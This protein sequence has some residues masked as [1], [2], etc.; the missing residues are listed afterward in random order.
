MREP[1]S[2]TPLLDSF[3][4]PL[5]PSMDFTGLL[6]EGIQA[7]QAMSSDQWTD[8]NEHDPGLT[9]LEQL[10]YA[11]TDLGLR[12]HYRVEDLLADANGRIDR[13]SLF[14]GNDIL[15]CAPLT[16]NDYR[17]YLYD[18]V[19]GLKNIWLEPVVGALPGLYRGLIEKFRWGNDDALMAD[20][21]RHLH[22]NRLLGDELVSVS[23]LRQQALPL[24]GIIQLKPGYQADQVMGDVLFNLDLKLAPCPIPRPIDARLA[25]GEPPDEIY[26]GP[27]LHY[28]SIDDADLQPRPTQVSL[29][30]IASIVLATAGV[31]RLSQLHFVPDPTQETLTLDP[32]SIPFID[33]PEAGADWPFQVIN[34]EGTPVTLN[35]ARV[36]HYFLKNRSD[37]L[38]REAAV[39]LSTASLAYGQLPSGRALEIGRYDSIQHQFPQT[40]GLGRYGVPADLNWQANDESALFAPEVVSAGVRRQAQVKQ[41]RAYLLLFEQVLSNAFAQLANAHQLFA[42]APASAQ[43]YFAQSLVGDASQPYAPPN[44][45]EVLAPPEPPAEPDHRWR[46]I[47]CVYLDGHTLCLRSARLASPQAAS[48]LAE[49]IAQAGRQPGNYRQQPDGQGRVQ[50]QLCDDDGVALAYAVQPSTSAADAQALIQRLLGQLSQAQAQ[51]A[52]RQHRQGTLGLRI[53]GARGEL[54]LC[55]YWPGRLAERPAKVDDVLFFG[56]YPHHYSYRRWPD[57]HWGLVLRHPDGHTLAVSPQR[58]ASETACCHAAHALADWVR[59]LACQCAPTGKHLQLLPEQDV[60]PPGPS[61]RQH[62]LAELNHLMARFD[63]YPERRNRFLNH[64]LARFNEHF[65]D[66]LLYSFDPRPA[67]TDGFLLELASWKAALL[68]N[69][70]LWSARRGHGHNFTLRL[71]QPLP[72][73][74]GLEQ[75]LAA[76][77]G[78]GGAQP[79][80][81]YPRSRAPLSATPPITLADSQ[82]DD[83]HTLQFSSQDPNLLGMLFKY[84][85]DE[86]RYQITHSDCGCFHHLLFSYP[87]GSQKPIL[88]GHHRAGLEHSRDRLIAW[89]RPQGPAWASLYAGEGLYVVEHLLLRPPAAELDA[90]SDADK[91]FY[92]YRLSVLLPDWPIRFCNPEFRAYVNVLL[93]EHCPAHLDARCH[94]LD[95]DQMRQFETLYAAWARQKTLSLHAAASAAQLEAATQ[96]LR[97]FLQALPAPTP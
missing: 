49:R 25:A 58:H 4:D 93:A 2:P 52:I 71:A 45:L 73:G 42:L 1:S 65:D 77:L 27:L 37:G 22:A 32:D 36:R 26:Q 94:W 87:D 96:A 89:L 31:Q 86:G 29:Q 16:P 90:L 72:C 23:V 19:A 13:N 8:Y 55:A 97:Q 40:Y 33:L 5:P 74:S 15:T 3:P 51:H 83:R 80:Q 85:A 60:P 43:S 95:I 53:T 28:G 44:T 81:R 67:N 57:G 14:T 91:D 64:L 38:T 92:R 54:L 78:L 63:P 11:L 7:T 35:A 47:V 12:G 50:V 59:Q 20:V 56:R 61:L 84:G 18:R 24:H 68:F 46:Q 69:Y 10:A 41:L 75:L 70:P 88:R 48:R 30:H 82:A 62:Y 39:K 76:R 34:A 79:L 17:K 6:A 21:S 66:A 9:I